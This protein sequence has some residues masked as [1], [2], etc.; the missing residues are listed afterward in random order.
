VLTLRAPPPISGNEALLNV[1]GF[2]QETQ[3]YEYRVNEN[4]GTLNRSGTPYQIQLGA[5]LSF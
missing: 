2:D 4:F 5:R 1:T 3:Q